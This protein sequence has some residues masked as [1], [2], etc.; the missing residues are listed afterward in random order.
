MERK[1]WD[2]SDLGQRLA[3]GED[4]AFNEV[5][6][7]YSAKVYGLC[8]RILRNQEEAQ[9]LTQEVFVR[10][11]LKRK[12][13]KGRSALYTWIYRIAVNMCLSHLKKRKAQTVPLHEVE[14]MLAA[15]PAE[16]S[17]SRVELDQLLAKA[18]ESVPPKQRAVF[19]LRFYDKMSFNEIA[20]AMGTSVG[21]AKANHHFAV[22][23]LRQL[24]QGVDVK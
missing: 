10:V 20:E 7:R 19:S 17:D 11:Y 16:T 5:V 4:D 6:E 2:M 9:D 14:G 12:S 1:R 15:T 13:F 18:L 24:L 21:A 23:R 8:Y 3:S 22:E